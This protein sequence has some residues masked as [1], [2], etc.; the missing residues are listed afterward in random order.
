MTLKTV[1][2][3]PSALKIWKKKKWKNYDD[4]SLKWYLEKFKRNGEKWSAVERNSL[5]I[6]ESN[7][8]QINHFVV[9]EFK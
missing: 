5:F 2:M 4:S 7:H 8:W 3:F 1:D 9:F 6:E